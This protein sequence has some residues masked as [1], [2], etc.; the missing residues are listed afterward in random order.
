MICL[1]SLNLVRNFNS[2][3]CE[4]CSEKAGLEKTVQAAQSSN[5]ILK[6][7]C[8]KLQLTVTSMQ[9]ERDHEREEKEAAI[10]ERDRA[11]AETQ[12]M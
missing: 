7:D 9:R 10:Q 2:P 3:N 8:E 11:K 1:L 12:R 6:M 4:H 5:Q